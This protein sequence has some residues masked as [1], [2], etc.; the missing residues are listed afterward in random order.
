MVAA[1]DLG[2]IGFV[3]AGYVRDLVNA[4]FGVVFLLLIRQVFAS[5]AMYNPLGDDRDFSPAP[6]LKDLLIGVALALGAVGWAAAYETAV[7]LRFLPDTEL[8]GHFLG[9]IPLFGLI[10]VFIFFLG[11]AIVRLMFG[12]RRSTHRA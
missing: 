1:L 9:L 5:G 3:P 2:C 8:P 11:R 4:G 6:V 7:R 10:S 12:Q